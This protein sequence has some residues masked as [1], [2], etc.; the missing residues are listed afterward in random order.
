MSTFLR[1]DKDLFKL[2]LS[3]IEILLLAQVMEFQRT[4][5][6]FFMSDKVLAEMLCVSEKTVSRAW[7]ALEAR[8]FIVRKTVNVRGGRERHISAVL[9]AIHEALTTDNLTVDDS[10]TDKKSFVQQTNCP[11]YNGQNDLI[12]Y[13]DEK[14]K[15]KIA[16]C[17][18]S[19]STSQSTNGCVGGAGIVPTA[20]KFE[21]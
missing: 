21:F 2:G 3:P 4:T 5:G 17:A 13:K 8:G 7:T 15:E 18:G 1:V 12:K 20:G 6:D 9:N 10:T 14:E 16:A 19:S 11:L